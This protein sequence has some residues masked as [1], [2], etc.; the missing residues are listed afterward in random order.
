MKYAGLVPSKTK[1]LRHREEE[2]QTLSLE[3]ALLQHVLSKRSG[4][5][6]QT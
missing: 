5:R 6:S 3:K 1:L 2:W 4:A